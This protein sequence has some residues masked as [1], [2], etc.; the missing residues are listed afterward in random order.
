[1]NN[2]TRNILLSALCF[3]FPFSIYFI[4]QSSSLMFDDAAEF[5]TVIKQASNAHPPGF[6]A[7]IFLGMLWDKVLS[8]FSH[9]TIFILNLFS[10]TVSSVASLLFYKTIRTILIHSD[11][12]QSASVKKDFVA[13][14]TALCFATELTSWTWSN[15][16]EVY[17]FQLFAM[18]LLLFGLVHFHFTRKTSYIV[19]ASLGFAFGLSNH[20]LTVILFAP[21]IPFFFFTDL[22]VAKDELQNDKKKKAKATKKNFLKE[23]VSVFRMKPFWMMTVI[24]T[25]VTFSFYF[26]MYLRAQHDY[27][28]MFGKPDSL[29]ELMYHVTGRSYAKNIEET[30]KN[31][32]QSRIPYFFQLTFFQ[33]LFFLPLL[34]AGLVTMLKKKMSGLFTVVMLYF[35][36]LLIYQVNNN[37]WENTDAYMLLPFMVLTIPV[38][39]GS[40]SLFEKLK[41]KY[42]L[43]LILILQTAINFPKCNR[44]DYNVSESL[45]HQLD[46]SA[47]KN[48]IIIIAD[49]S[50]VI[51][52]YYSRIVE[53]FRPDLVVLNGDVKFN[54]Y[55]VIQ[56]LYPD[57][58]LSIKPEY[59]SFIDELGKEHPEQV[60]GTGCDLS[61][62]KLMDTFHAMITK[63]ETLASSQNR[64]LLTDPRAHY[65]MVQQH[66]YS[67]NRYV[68]GC[69]VSSMKTDNNDEYLRF[70]MKWLTSPM[71]QSD[72]TALNKM[73]DYQ[74][75]FDSHIAYYTAVNDNARLA[76]ALEAKEKVMKI[77]RDLK[78]N[79]S[80]AYKLK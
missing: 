63:I 19:L 77:Q 48:S 37:Q 8:Q 59:D 13:A 10:I 29:H 78:K 21:F 3:V 52:Y 42:I 33:F 74:A 50:L 7:Y 16:I 60:T 76:K 30:S 64:A 22:F 65:F 31:I 75:M 34:V 66:F 11:K 14:A 68:S 51:Q 58:Y 24:T 32:L 55:K 41:L 62:Q 9:H 15:T 28:F 1:M 26:W 54:H 40:M 57:F 39:Y 69:F 79:I 44:R 45:M 47:P 72:L 36:F 12:D 67:P 73:V 23:Y 49:W 38:A 46:V 25:A 5:A 2:R 4:T 6:P 61:T 56:I 27:P 20:H 17:A 43:P 35:L 70:D 71:L 18:S 53:N 80:F